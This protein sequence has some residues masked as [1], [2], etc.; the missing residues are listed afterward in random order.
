MIRKIKKNDEK[1]DPSR[2]FRK[3]KK[4]LE[5]VSWKINIDQTTMRHHLKLLLIPNVTYVYILKCISMHVN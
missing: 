1:I 2:H 4:W 3:K 5:I